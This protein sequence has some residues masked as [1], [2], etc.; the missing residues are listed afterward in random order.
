MAARA[1][2]G[3]SPAAMR[4]AP[5]PTPVGPWRRAFGAAL[6]LV[7]LVLVVL[8]PLMAAWVASSLAAHA[9]WRVG[10]AAA[11]GLLVFPVLPVA[12]E[13]V[14]SWRASRRPVRGRPWLSRGDRVVLRTLAVSAAFVAA[15]LAL[16][17]QR[18]FVALNSRGDW[19]LDGHHDP[20]AESV[21]RG[22]FWGAARFQWLAQRARD[23]AQR[24]IARPLPV[25]VARVQP[26][27]IDNPAAPRP[28][29]PPS[30]PRD[31]HAWPWD[32]VLHPA[33]AALP[34]S[35]ET[36][37][38]A[39]GRYLAAAES[40]PWRRARAV[41]DYVAD[42][43]AYDVAAYRAGVYPPQDAATTFQTRRSVCAGY[44]ALFESIGRAAGLT[45]ET[46]TG[47]ARGLVHAGMG[48]AHAWSA[49]RL[50]GRW[51]LVDTT[52]DAGHV[53]A[54]GFHKQFGTRYFLA[55]PEVFGTKHFPDEARWQLLPVA[56][57]EGEYLRTPALDPRFFAHGLRLV[58]PDR[59]ESDARASF[60]LTV[61]N[62]EGASLMVSV[63]PDGGASL[64]CALEGEGRVTARCPLAGDGLHE[65]MLFVAR[66][67]YG[68]HW[69]AGVLRVHNR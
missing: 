15:L 4:T 20:R 21:R 14:A 31:P 1:S 42:R 66:E 46:V 11:S 43:V 67:R 39:V 64:A 25:G 19:M 13:L 26:T 56:R 6:S 62:P 8:A 36:S 69:S 48:E 68:T 55:P 28:S 22:L 35:V 29:R 17:P 12:W 65:V 49:V 51:H 50:D 37:P 16:D 59:A 7:W 5:R 32:D 34:A 63:R 44:A 10:A 41:H 18:A 53:D 58:S 2:Q 33:V 27:P 24:P 57:T 54:D 52:W 47:R 40:D 61:D 23:E 30:P 38:E 9:G 60:A 3:P 45:V